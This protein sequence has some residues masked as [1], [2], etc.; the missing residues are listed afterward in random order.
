M[1]VSGTTSFVVTRDDVIQAAMRKL[2][3]LE[4]GSTPTAQSVTNFSFALNLILKNWQKDGIKLW[5]IGN[6]TVPLQASK[7]SYSIGPYGTTSDITS[8]KPLKVVG[9]FLRNTSTSPNIDMP[10]QILSRQEY[11]LLGSKFSTGL[12]NSIYYEP[13][14]LSGVVTIFMTPD[15]NTSTNYQ[16]ILVVQRSIMDV[17]LSTDNFDLP[18]EWY[19]PLQWALAA[20]M[21]SD[22]E[23]SLQDRAYFDQKAIYYKKEVEDWDVENTSVQFIPDMRMAQRGFR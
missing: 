6:L 15:T 16:L 18:A 19:L 23:K 20:E 12:T 2:S 9:A 8:D 5:T 17:N 14:L 21:S 7:T 1:S 4:E 22:Y 11:N 3:V 13:G 10:M